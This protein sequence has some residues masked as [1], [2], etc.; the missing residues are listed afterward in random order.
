MHLKG[1]KAK[2][3]DFDSA[4]LRR[5]GFKAIFG[6]NAQFS[7]DG[8]PKARVSGNSPRYLPRRFYALTAAG[9]AIL[10]FSSEPAAD[11]CRFRKARHN[12]SGPPHPESACRQ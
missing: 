4:M 8:D 12:P 3:G 2:A 9:Q 11:H 7:V 5:A 1:R 6:I 10:N